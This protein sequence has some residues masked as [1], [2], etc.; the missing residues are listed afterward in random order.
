MRT[1][2]ESKLTTIASAQTK[3]SEP[4]ILN[5][6]VHLTKL[7]AQLDDGLEL[8]IPL[9]SFAKSGVKGVSAEKLKKYE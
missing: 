1:R 2:I 5:L 8:S 3:K 4:K 6:A 7:T 9:D